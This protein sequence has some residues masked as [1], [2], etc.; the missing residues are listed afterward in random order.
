MSGRSSRQRGHR[1]EQTLARVLTE[2]TGLDIRT[3]R[4][5]GLTYGAD[6]VTVTGYDAHERP[7]T[8]DPHILGWSIE[9]KNVATRC[10]K[11]W[12]RQADQQKAPGTVPVVLW[13]RRHH[14]FEK[15]SAFLLDDEAPRGWV[16]LGIDEFL[17][18]L[19]D[20]EDYQP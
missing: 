4:Y 8:Y 16:E 14:P 5:F 11:A 2:T 20:R 10:P 17:D 12:L 7:V 6:L 19:S 1:W 9:A 13:N 18:N 3:G 15:G